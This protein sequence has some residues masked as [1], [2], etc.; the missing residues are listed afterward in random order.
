MGA[1]GVGFFSLLFADDVVLVSL[2]GDLQH[3]LNSFAPKCEV[4][5]IRISTSE[6]ETMVLSLKKMKGSLD[7]DECGLK[8][9]SVC[10]GDGGSLQQLL[11]PVEAVFDIWLGCLLDSSLHPFCDHQSLLT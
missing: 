9:T 10:L 5:G 8:W 6:P 1:S 4:A 11:E 3:S 7:Q 2:I